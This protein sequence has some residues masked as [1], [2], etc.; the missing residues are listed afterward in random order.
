[1]RLA[2]LSMVIVAP[3]DAAN[4]ASERIRA[5]VPDGV[6]FEDVEVREVV[7]HA[8]ERLWP[9]RRRIGA[10]FQHPEHR[11]CLPLSLRACRACAAA[12]LATVGHH[13][14]PRKTLRDV[15]P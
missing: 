11:F 4:G 2:T 1:M 6:T 10:L 15:A 5:N 14:C 9:L 13:P 12:T 3:E 7:A 8:R